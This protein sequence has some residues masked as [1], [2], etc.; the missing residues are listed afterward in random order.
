M[1]FTVPEDDLGQILPQMKKRVKLTVDA[2]DR[3]AQT[4]IA[5]GTLLTLDNL[6]DTTTGTVKARAQFANAD[7]ALFPNQFVNARLT[8]NT[9]RDVTIIPTAAVQHNAQA[10][11]VYRI[12]AG[13]VHVTPITVGV[14]DGL[15]AQV[16]GIN[17]GDQ[18]ATSGFEKLQ[19]NSQV[20]I[21]AGNGGGAGAGGG[22]RGGHGG[23]PGNSG[24]QD[25]S[26]RPGYG[27]GNGDGA[28]S[29]SSH[30]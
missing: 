29:G 14:V 8:V 18:V 17:P 3:T 28:P 1:V 15:T 2:F 13:K 24:G 22:T 23:R 11:F 27:P 4:K 7:G 6:I 30:P 9:L 26:H 5:S 20:T 10:A 19:E 16:T 21:S 25:G 12:Q